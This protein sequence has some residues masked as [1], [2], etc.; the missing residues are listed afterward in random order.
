MTIFLKVFVVWHEWSQYVIL[1]NHNKTP[2]SD[3][4]TL[5][6]CHNTEH[7]ERGFG[8]KS[9]PCCG[10]SF[11]AFIV[12]H[13]H[14]MRKLTCSHDHHQLPAYSAHATNMSARPSCKYT[15]VLPRT[16]ILALS[17][18]VFRLNSVG[19]GNCM[20]RKVAKT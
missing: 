20:G 7:K 17:V 13:V 3:M 18:K 5:R 4:L 2:I 10:S 16:V 12:Y 14:C 8:R 15:G 9:C 1:L 11:L 19:L 6:K